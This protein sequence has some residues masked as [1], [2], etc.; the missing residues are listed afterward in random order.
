MPEESA[1]QAAG[2]EGAAQG[3]GNATGAQTA[4]QTTEGA[5]GATGAAT[6]APD[7]REGLEPELKDF[8]KNLSTPADAAREALKMRKE[9]SGRIKLP[10]K[11]AK[12]EE[13]ASFRKAMGVP[14]KADG[15]KFPEP[16]A[17]KELTDQDKA[18]RTEIATV[19][20]EENIPSRAAERLTGVVMKLAEAQEAEWD[21]VAKKGRQDAEAKLK[22]EWAGD[23][24]KH[25]TEMKRAVAEF[26]GDELRE[27]ADNTYVDGVKLGDHPVYLKSWAKVG[28]R[29]GERGFIAP[30]G[31]E[32]SQTLVAEKEKLMR[33]N[34]PGT[35]KYKSAAVQKRLAEINEAL[36]GA[37]PIVGAAGRT[38]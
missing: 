6:A 29:M 18:V 34:P 10:A 16:P 5:A 38:V 22:Q 21:R 7:W 4:T 9:L 12:P 25:T 31:G 36:H 30:V 32:G 13:V 17:G 23:F 15:Y 27:F 26:G 37:E 8:A 19:M 24:D 35:D 1:G 33:D 3:A 28:A 11:D 2:T 14:D 20:H